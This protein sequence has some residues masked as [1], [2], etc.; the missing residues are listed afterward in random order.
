M[1]RDRERSRDAVERSQHG[2]LAYSVSHCC[3]ELD[4]DTS[5]VDFETQCSSVTSSVSESHSPTA[6]S[7]R[8]NVRIWPVRGPWVHPC[9]ACAGNGTM[10]SPIRVFCY[11]EIGEQTKY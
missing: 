6:E 2:H 5:R 7:I 4:S 8:A 10:Q 1:S 3:C 11:G 9:D